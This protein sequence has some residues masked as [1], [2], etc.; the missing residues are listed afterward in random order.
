MK[1]KDRDV[2]KISLIHHLCLQFGEGQSAIHDISA[3]LCSIPREMLRRLEGS[4]AWRVQQEDNGNRFGCE[5][6]KVLDAL[7]GRL[8]LAARHGGR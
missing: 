4:I 6:R 1:W 8:Q 3:W 7:Q 2:R 5:E